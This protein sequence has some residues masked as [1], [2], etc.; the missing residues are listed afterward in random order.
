MKQKFTIY[1]DNEVYQM[2][3]YKDIAIENAHILSWLR[4]GSTISVV[5]DSTGKI[6]FNKRG[7]YRQDENTD[8]KRPA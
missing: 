8:R 1:V 7:E 5:D 6:I 3:Y 2:V 4:S